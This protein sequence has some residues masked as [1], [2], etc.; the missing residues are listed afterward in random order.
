MRYILTILCVAISVVSR[1]QNAITT[2]DTTDAYKFILDYM[3]PASPAFTVLDVA[4]QQVSRGS[5]AKPLVFNAFT[6]FLQSGRLDPGIAADFSP[7]VL[8]G[9]GFKN[10][11]EYRKDWG[12]RVLANSMISVAALKNSDDTA[13]TDFGVGLRVTLLDDRDLFANSGTARTVAD[14]IGNALADAAKAP[15]ITG[16]I[17]DDEIGTSG[18]PGGT[19][20]VDLDRFYTDAYNSI[21]NVP[22]WAISLGFGYRATARSSSL[23]SDSLM[24]EQTRLWISSTRYTDGGYDVYWTLQGTFSGAHSSKWIGGLAAGSKNKISNMGAE[25]VYDFSAKEWNYG[26]NFEI[27]ILKQFTYIVFLGKR[28]VFLNGVDISDRFRII[29]NLRLNLFGH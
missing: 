27:R 12:R 29:S 13:H 11:E 24:N 5:A 14:N 26:A 3:V 7:Y 2:A 15:V 18:T 10:L 23:H 9:G 22:G 4:P 20:A 21:R 8:L 16:Q 19:I 28:S 17:P 1:A 6:N 25:L